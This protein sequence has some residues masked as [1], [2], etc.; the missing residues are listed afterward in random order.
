MEGHILQ[1][2][3]KAEEMC[4][5]ISDL[6]MLEQRRLLSRQDFSSASLPYHVFPRP[7]SLS[8]GPVDALFLSKD[9]HNNCMRFQRSFV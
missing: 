8:L 3:H 1:A 9:T 7:A 6:S 5:S 2:N 4:V